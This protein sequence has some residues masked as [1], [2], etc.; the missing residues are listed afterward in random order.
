MPPSS[1]S[2]LQPGDVLLARG[3]ARTRE[4][5]I[6]GYRRVARHFSPARAESL[7]I[8]LAGAAVGWRRM[9]SIACSR[10][11]VLMAPRGRLAN[12]LASTFFAIVAAG[13]ASAVRLTPARARRPLAIVEVIG[14]R[15]SG[16]ALWFRVG[17]ASADVVRFRVGG[18]FARRH[19]VRE[20]LAVDSGVVRLLLLLVWDVPLEPSLIEEG[21]GRRSP[22]GLLR[23]SNPCPPGIPTVARMHR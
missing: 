2:L 16:A 17:A 1:R 12:R 10:R 11:C 22:R 9:G 18:A 14:A 3:A 8:A 23:S 19:A 4:L 6:S 5:T 13:F 7:L 21:A 15:L 20:A